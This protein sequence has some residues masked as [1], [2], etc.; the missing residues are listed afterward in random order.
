MGCR[1]EHFPAFVRAVFM[2]TN[3]RGALITM[4]HKVTAVTLLDEVVAGGARRGL[5]AMPSDAPPTAAWKAICSMGK[6]SC[7]VFAARAVGLDG[8]RALV[9]GA[10]GVGSAIAASLAAAGVA[11]LSLVDTRSEA[12][13]A[14]AARLTARHPRLE[15]S[16][17]ERDPA[18][19]DVVVNATPCGM[20]P[21]DPVPIDVARVR[22]DA[23]VGD[24][25]MADGT[26]RLVAA[27][28]TRGCRV[29]EG[30]DMLF[31]QIPL[32]L[33]FFGLPP[34]TPE[35]LRRVAHLDVSGPA[36]RPGGS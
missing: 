22:P 31:E 26:T 18:S 36:N 21:E 17:G 23:F 1:A 10:G 7:A 13:P 4:P 20:R 33:E 35:H 19:Y 8:V 29:L 24:V 3:I 14:L 2:L 15:I 11:A 27:A 30:V 28:R 12:A 6:A 32:Y 9:V 25:V 16:V 34:T 5:R